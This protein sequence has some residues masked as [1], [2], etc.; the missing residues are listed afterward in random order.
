[1]QV[2][3]G[4]VKG[5]CLRPFAQP[6]HNGFVGFLFLLLGA[7]R[8]RGLAFGMREREQSRQQRQGLG[9]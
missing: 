9:W 6:C 1:M 5:G 4:I 7:Q 8:N 2:F 3:P